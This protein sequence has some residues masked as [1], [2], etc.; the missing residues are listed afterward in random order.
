M[1]PVF[2]LVPH[3]PEKA[4]RGLWSPIWEQGDTRWQRPQ[5]QDRSVCKVKSLQSRRSCST[6][7]QEAPSRR[8]AHAT[9]EI[10]NRRR[11]ICGAL[12]SPRRHRR[13]RARSCR[14]RAR[15]AL[16]FQTRWRT[17]GT[18]SCRLLVRSGDKC[19]YCWLPTGDGD[20]LCDDNGREGNQWRLSC[21][22]LCYE[23]KAYKK[24]ICRHCAVCGLVQGSGRWLFNLHAWPRKL[25][26]YWIGCHHAV[27]SL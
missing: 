6:H 17:A 25:D 15:G 4:S 23:I 18:T 16:C 14:A 12:P 27:W 24:C 19:V 1:L 20:K 26:F 2:L 8:F 21:H 3:V 9:A 13:R 5:T 11:P 7:Q 22:D 10:P